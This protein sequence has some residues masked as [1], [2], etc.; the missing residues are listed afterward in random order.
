MSDT[1]S[2]SPSKLKGRTADTLFSKLV[3]HRQEGS[4]L[5]QRTGGQP[6]TW[7]RQTSTR[8]SLTECSERTRRSRSS[9]L[10]EAKSMVCGGATVRTAQSVKKKRVELDKLLRSSGM[11]IAGNPKSGTALAIKANL[12]LPWAGVR[13]LRCWFTMFGVPSESEGEKRAQLAEELP[14]QVL[15]DELPLFNRAGDIIM[16]PVMRYGDLMKFAY[17]DLLKFAYGDLLKVVLHYLDMYDSAKILTWRDGAIPEREVWQKSVG[18]RGGGG[19]SFKMLFQVANLDQLNALQY[20]IPFLVVAGKDLP[21]TKNVAGCRG[22]TDSK[23]ISQFCTHSFSVAEAV[24]GCRTV[25]THARVTIVHVIC[26]SC[27]STAVASVMRNKHLAMYKQLCNWK[28]A[29]ACKAG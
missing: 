28:A 2:A 20:T 6:F 5:T 25:R 10:E 12:S 7:L 9:S 8:V 22:V 26:N 19:K 27:S 24:R 18:I 14:F 15:V 11:I 23:L 1:L 16:T 3:S 13:K 17:G 21:S 4:V 29:H